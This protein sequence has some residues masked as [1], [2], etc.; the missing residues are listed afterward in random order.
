MPKLFS[1]QTLYLAKKYG[2]SLLDRSISNDDLVKLSRSFKL[3][4]ESNDG[5]GQY[6][7]QEAYD[8]F[9][10][11]IGTYM[12]H[13]N[14]FYLNERLLDM[15][16]VIENHRGDDYLRNA[17]LARSFLAFE[18]RLHSFGKNLAPRIAAAT[19]DADVIDLIKEIKLPDVLKHHYQTIIIDW[20]QAKKDFAPKE[21]SRH[22]GFHLL[23]KLVLQ[24]LDKIDKSLHHSIFIKLKLFKQSGYD[25]PGNFAE[26]IYAFNPKHLNFEIN[27]YDLDKKQENLAVDIARHIEASKVKGLLDEQAIIAASNKDL[28]KLIQLDFLGLDLCCTV[29]N[30]MNL[31]HFS[32]KNQDL[33]TVSYL[34]NLPNYDPNMPMPN[35]NETALHLAVNLNN[36]K[37][38]ECLLQCSSI[39]VNLTNSDGWTP[40]HLAAH[41]GYTLIA[42]KLILA[43]A[44]PS[45]KVLH[46]G[47]VL[48]ASYTAAELAKNAGF[49]ETANQINWVASRLEAIELKRIS[50]LEYKVRRLE[51]ANKNLEEIVN[52]LKL[53]FQLFTYVHRPLP[54][55]SSPGW[56]RTLFKAEENHTL[57]Q[58]EK[59]VG[60]KF[61]RPS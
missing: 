25:F 59:V 3:K 24:D 58:H 47:G 7:L 27:D 23:Q 39:D 12:S 53:Q 46:K 5:E 50:G 36:V 51:E 4:N 31:L 20:L 22:V 10:R 48:K 44:D 18:A 55:P 38:V 17:S 26:Q 9:V 42:E 21:I 14:I 45:Q 19:S 37:L 52:T 1:T 35:T 6:T 30:G 41:L 56:K 34:L 60:N 61:N 16:G 28:D 54:V 40:L 8:N 2:S 11:Y 49:A 13:E 43:G 33:E 15:E 57:T 29:K 32:V